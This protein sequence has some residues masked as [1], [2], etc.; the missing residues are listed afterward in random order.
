MSQTGE[1]NLVQ[2]YHAVGNGVVVGGV[3]EL[4]VIGEKLKR[5]Q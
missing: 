3:G 1:R 4:G 2:S 5:S